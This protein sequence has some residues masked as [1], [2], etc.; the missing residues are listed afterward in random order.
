MKITKT[1]KAN[2]MVVLTMPEEAAE[3]I[4]EAVGKMEGVQ[5]VNDL[6]R[7]NI[8]ISQSSIL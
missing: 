4:I 8:L 1:L 5:C 3:F 2:H 7:L 6:E